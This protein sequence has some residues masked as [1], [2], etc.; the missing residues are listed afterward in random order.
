M[1]TLAGEPQEMLRG[2]APVRPV[3]LR[4]SVRLSGSSHMSVRAAQPDDVESIQSYV[5][6]L[7]SASRY[8]RFLGAVSELSATELHRA[9]HPSASSAS[10]VLETHRDAARTIIGEARWHLAANGHTCEFAA[11]ITDAWQR[12]GLGTWL[13]N[14]IAAR[15]RSLGAR[16]LLAEIL[17]A[18][19]PAQ[20]L[21]CNLGFHALPSNFDP[22]VMCFIKELEPSGR[23]VTSE[24]KPL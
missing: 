18:N 1:F 9:T 4:E 6:G 3:L 22:K 20:R 12:Q 2:Q 19:K 8:F 7:S 5:R 21:V 13:I 17:H 15:V 11:S 16:H 14:H 23:V 24:S 10:L